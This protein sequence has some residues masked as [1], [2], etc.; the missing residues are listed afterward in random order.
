MNLGLKKSF[1]FSLAT[2][3][4]VVRIFAICL[5]LASLNFGCTGSKAHVE[6]RTLPITE[7][8]L[9]FEEAMACFK[10]SSDPERDQTGTR[11]ALEKFKELIERFPESRFREKSKGMIKECKNR[12]A[13]H[14]YKIGK[15]YERPGKFASAI[16]YY[17]EVI[18]RYPESPLVE[19]CYFRIGVCNQKTRRFVEALGAYNEYLKRFPKGRWRLEVIAR[20]NEVEKETYNAK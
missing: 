19:E 7:D 9:L 13:L 8:Q 14:E 11:E 6:K 4:L 5:V 10:G 17:K 16:F 12:L 20:I 3:R 18:E 1:G 2:T 15:F